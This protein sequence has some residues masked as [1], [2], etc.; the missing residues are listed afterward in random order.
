MPNYPNYPSQPFTG[1]LPGMIAMGPAD[2]RASSSTAPRYAAKIDQQYGRH[3][4][5]V[6]EVQDEQAEAD[7]WATNELEY[8]QEMDDVQGS[9]IFDAPGTD[10]NIYPDAGVLADRYSL[11]G[12]LARE[13][14]YQKSEVSDVTTGRP[15]VYVNGG[16]VSM[17]SA[18]Q[19]A[20]LERDL[21]NPPSP[22]LSDQD[23]H[24]LPSVSMVN[25]QTPRRAVRGLG[26]DGGMSKETK[27]MLAAGAVVVALGFSA[28][29]LGLFSKK[30]KGR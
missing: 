27:V 23:V 5:G 21:Y 10:P 25:V 14:M 30:K 26:Q 17:D 20:F 3:L 16:A 6:G 7:G 11:P 28:G 2:L 19:V 12:Y 1:Q 9:G 22:V 29:A 4:A 18:A 8:L 13:R 24:N 15:V